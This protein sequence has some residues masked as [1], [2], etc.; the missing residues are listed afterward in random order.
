MTAILLVTLVPS[1]L[2]LVAPQ[3]AEAF[4]GC[5]PRPPVPA[6]IPIA[7]PVLD[8]GVITIT[9]QIGLAQNQITDRKCFLDFIVKTLSR[10]VVHAL[11]SSIIDWINRGFEGG[12]TFVTD[13][14]GFF[15]K[16]ADQ[17]IGRMIDG[18]GLGFVCDPFRLQ[19]QLSF[20]RE[21]DR[22]TAPSRCSITGIVKNLQGFV[23]GD[24]SQGGWP[25]WISMTSQ[26]QN[27]PFGSQLMGEEIVAARVT[28]RQN[29]AK[30]TLD[31]GKGFKSL[32]SSDGTI[33][34]PGNL[35]NDQLSKAT[36]NELDYLNLARE[37]DDIVIALANLGISK[38]MSSG[39]K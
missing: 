31:W 21:R 26:A 30:V 10:A 22:Y 7:V 36:G 13:P 12:P 2:P 3:K 15:G 25:G 28:S 6:V 32:L 16:I 1:D 38:I 23:G 35:I 37:F 9:T 5:I 4:F 24:F 19:L 8:L 34:T 17:E 27:N 20:L 18:S 29:T 11:V 14:A 39:L 33:K